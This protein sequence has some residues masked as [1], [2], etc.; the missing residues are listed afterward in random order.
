MP[1]MAIPPIQ[2][3]VT[4]RNSRQSRP[5]G[6]SRTPERWSGILTRPWIR[7]SSCKSCC[8][9]TELAVGLTCWALEGIDVATISNNAQAPRTR[10]MHFPKDAI[11]FLPD[12]LPFAAAPPL[13]LD[14]L[15]IGGLP[16]PGPGAVPALGHAFLVDLG[17][18]FAIAQIYKERVT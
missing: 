15:A 5:A 4:L 3:S 8:S 6:C 7:L 14:G 9:F 10:R 18:D 1:R 2:R 13:G 12:I 16:A 17:D 11:S